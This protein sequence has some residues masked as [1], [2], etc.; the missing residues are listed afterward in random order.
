MVQGSCTS[1]ARVQPLVLPKCGNPRPVRLQTLDLQQSSNDPCRKRRSRIIR[2]AGLPERGP[3]LARRPTCA[4]PRTHARQTGPDKSSR[5][6]SLLQ[7]E[8]EATCCLQD[9]GRG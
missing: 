7:E 5:E 2:P 8:G 3:A 4:S 9:E 1:A 6:T